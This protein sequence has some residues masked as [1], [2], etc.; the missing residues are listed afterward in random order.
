VIGCGLSNKVLGLSGGLTADGT[1]LM[2]ADY[3][4]GDQT[5]LWKVVPAADGWS[6]VENAKSGTVMTA[7][8][9][10]NGTEVT[11]AKKQTPPSDNQLWKVVASPA[12]KGAQ[13]LYAKPSGKYIG[14]DAKSKEAGAR[15]LLWA[16]QPTEAA[17][18][19]WINPPK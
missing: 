10:G 12:A 8:G 5:Q 6:Y 11:I 16:D 15:I 2:T 13:R 9:A 1:K 14:V 7:N 4:K 17:Q 3:V 18:F 19:F